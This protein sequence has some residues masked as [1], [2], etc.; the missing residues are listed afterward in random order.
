MRMHVD[1]GAARGAL[2]SCRGMALLVGEVCCAAAAAVSLPLL[3]SPLAELVRRKETHQ[4][5]CSIDMT[6]IKQMRGGIDDAHPACC[7]HEVRV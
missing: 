2:G 6:C 5:T 4:R 3:R 7:A 1:D